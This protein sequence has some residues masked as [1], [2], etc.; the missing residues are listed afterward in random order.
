M[1]LQLLLGLA[2]SFVGAHG[3]HQISSFEEHR[4]QGIL[5]LLRL[6]LFPTTCIR[7]IPLEI[8]SRRIVPT[9]IFRGAI[10]WCILLDYLGRGR[11]HVVRLLALVL[12]RCPKYATLNTFSILRARQA[13]R[14][15]IV[16]SRALHA[17]VVEGLR[18]VPL[19]PALTVKL[20]CVDRRLLRKLGNI[21]PLAHVVIVESASL[22][23]HDGRGGSRWRV[24][25]LH[26]VPV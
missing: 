21:Q 15:F 7:V 8:A 25:L 13:L 24:P 9:S 16:C 2:G 4:A 14:Q 11:H 5:Q 18:G 12:L 19:A 10:H 17:A 3:V 26:H 6:L 1:D 23:V 20:T 22:R